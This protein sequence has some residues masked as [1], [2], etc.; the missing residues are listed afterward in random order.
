MRSTGFVTF[1]V[2]DDKAILRSLSRLLAANGYEVRPYGN[3][4][5]F[6]ANHDPMIPGCAILD[7]SMPG[8]SGLD[9]QKALVNEHAVR[10]IVFLSGSAD[11]PVS[12][13][14]MKE[15]AV[16]FLTKPV[17]SA[18]LLAAIAIACDRHA[19]AIERD[20]KV[21]ELLTRLANLTPRER[22]VLDGVVAGRLNKQI[23]GDIGISL[24]TTK[25]HR[26]S[27]M[28]KMNVRSVADLVRLASVPEGSADNP[29][30][31]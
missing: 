25:M 4:E 1:V 5:D 21:R 15:G 2:D 11:V 18:D 24:K 14:A 16:D 20:G 23:A 8:L 22:Q 7:V 9:I 6:L 26:G 28:K 31:N 10:P 30:K 29:S 12:V 27:M 13:Q 17:K 19:K 3:A